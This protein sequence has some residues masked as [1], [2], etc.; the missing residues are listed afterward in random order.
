MYALMQAALIPVF[1]FFDFFPKTFIF[2]EPLNNFEQNLRYRRQNISFTAPEKV[3]R[4][5]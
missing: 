5:Y 4:K 1:D 2:F 3:R